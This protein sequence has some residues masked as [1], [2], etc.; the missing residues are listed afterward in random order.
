MVQ[1]P[2]G[3]R[4]ERLARAHPRG[5]FRCSEAAVDAW[6]AT[7]AFQHQEKHLSAT[8]VL[9]DE[10]GQIAGYYTLATAQIDFGDL[11]TELTRQ[12][13]RRMLP[14]AVLAW[15]G[16]AT[17]RQNQGLGGRLVAQALL[18]CQHAGQTF[19]FVAVIL[20]CLNDAAKSFYQQWDFQELPGYPYRLFLSAKRLEALMRGR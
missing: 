11:P 4:I 13:P 8:K 16:V 1:F 14:V 17:N 6:L 19:A 3:F 2:A 12:L 9:L 15:L 10:T 7:K 20:D 5:R 18:D